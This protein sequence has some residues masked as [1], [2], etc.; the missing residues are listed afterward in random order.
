MNSSILEM[1]E[2][3]DHLRSMSRDL[4]EL[5]EAV[6]ALRN[7]YENA[8][9]EQTECWWPDCQSEPLRS[10]LSKWSVWVPKLRALDYMTNKESNKNEEA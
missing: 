9:E 2:T 1:Q 6:E 8:M 10:A 5:G 4:D 7:E 3:L